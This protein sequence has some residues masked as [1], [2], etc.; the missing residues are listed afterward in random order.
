MW[1]LALQTMLRSWP[2]SRSRHRRTTTTWF[3][4]V[5]ALLIVAIVLAALVPRGSMATSRVG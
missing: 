3:G 2:S 5:P 1:M 4:D